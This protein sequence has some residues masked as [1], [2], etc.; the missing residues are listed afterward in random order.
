MAQKMSGILGIEIPSICVCTA[1]SYMMER[2]QKEYHNETWKRVLVISKDDMWK[3]V[4]TCGEE[5]QTFV[6]EDYEKEKYM[7]ET[8]IAE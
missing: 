1:M 6:K 5:F 4:L 2:I 8:C 3:S 7:N